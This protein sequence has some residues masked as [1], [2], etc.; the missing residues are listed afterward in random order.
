MKEPIQQFADIGL[1]HHL[2]YPACMNDP[3]YHVKTL[4]GML[5]R[6]DITTLDCCLPYGEKERKEISEAALK[7]GK[8]LYYAF[9]FAPARKYSFGSLQHGEQGL[10]KL[11]VKDAIEAAQMIGAKGFIFGSGLDVPGPDRKKAMAAFREF[12]LWFCEAAAHCKMEVLLEPFDRYMDKKFLYGSSEESAELAGSVKKQFENFGIEL[13]MAHVPLMEETF[14][15]AIKNCAPYLRRVHL[16]NCV[17][18]FPGDPFFGDNHPPIGYEKGQH[19]TAELKN[20]LSLLCQYGYLKSGKK[21][22]LVLEMQPF[23]GKTEEETVADNFQ[24][25]EEAWREV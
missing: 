11:F 14:E 21:S 16:G 6:K 3:A 13:D 23:P 8:D 4:L 9:H 12:C 7:S 5:S 2:L 19:G 25:L 15:R 24:R 22:S 10:L 1:V 17:M 20:F 18:R